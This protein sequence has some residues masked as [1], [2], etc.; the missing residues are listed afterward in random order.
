[1]RQKITESRLARLACALV[2]ILHDIIGQTG[3][4][5][6]ITTRVE[7]SIIAIKQGNCGKAIRRQLLQVL[8]APSAVDR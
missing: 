5:G 7:G 6:L 3:Q 2:D 1:M 8:P 4:Y